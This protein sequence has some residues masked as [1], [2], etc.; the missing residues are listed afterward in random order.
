MNDGQANSFVIA[1]PEKCIGCKACEIACFAVHN[2]YNGVGAAAGTVNVPVI[3]RLYVIRT[4]SL[5]MPVQCRHC[6]NAPCAEACPVNAIIQQDGAI[7][8]D[9]ARC[10]GCKSC[11]LACPFGAIALFQAYSGGSENNNTRLKK[12]QDAA[13]ER[14]T[15]IIAYKCDL[16]RGA[17]PSE[18]R[19]ESGDQLGE[20]TPWC[21]SVC[22]EE[23]LTLMTPVK[24]EMSTRL[25]AVRRL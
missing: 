23:A 20:R 19:E 6:E 18:E 10:I 11:P 12:R 2:R 17:L 4:D 5:T 8:V 21:V 22:P 13:L 1:D 24:K 3:P 25:A 9:E 15:R 7:Q 16:C 14:K